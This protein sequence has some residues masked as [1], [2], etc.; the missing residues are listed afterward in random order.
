MKNYTLDRIQ[1]ILETEYGLILIKCSEIHKNYS[2]EFQLVTITGK[3]ICSP[4][5]L[6]T[7]KLFLTKNDFSCD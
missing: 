6:D 2:E 1:T 5:E 4:I 7:I 3:I